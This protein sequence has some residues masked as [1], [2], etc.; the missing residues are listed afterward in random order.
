MKQRKGQ[1][2]PINTIIM[3]AIGL[4]ILVIIIAMVYQRTTRFGTGL[5][6]VSENECAPENEIRPI[7]T[8]CE[9]IYAAFEDIGP[10]Q[11]CCRKGTAK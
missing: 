10:G 8:D 1:G 2:L 7:G 9:V 4:I 3:I 6:E 11:I 5:R